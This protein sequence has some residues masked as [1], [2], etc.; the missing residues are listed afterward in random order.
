[1]QLKNLIPFNFMY[2]IM[3]MK[4]GIPNICINLQSVPNIFYIYLISVSAMT[5]L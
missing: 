3:Q 5:S 2:E 1:M 4:M